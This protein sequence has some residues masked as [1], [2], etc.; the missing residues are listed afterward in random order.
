[1]VCQ[2]GDFEQ[3]FCG[4]HEHSGWQALCYIFASDHVRASSESLVELEADALQLAYALV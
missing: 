3:N 2:I 4:L 1:V